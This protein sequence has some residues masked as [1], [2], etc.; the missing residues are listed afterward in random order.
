MCIFN[1]EILTVLCGSLKSF[2]VL[3]YKKSQL[4][5][6]VFLNF[7]LFFTPTERNTY[8]CYQVY[9]CSQEITVQIKFTVPTLEPHGP[10]QGSMTLNKF[11]WTKSKQGR[12][13]LEKFRIQTMLI[14]Y[15]KDGSNLHC[16]L[17]RGHRRNPGLQIVQTSNFWDFM[18]F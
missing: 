4:D 13:Q 2:I 12:N 17:A 10:Q 11:P 5:F 3:L 1:L 15:K 6:V 14:S 9:N 7:I 18:F 8:N 16:F